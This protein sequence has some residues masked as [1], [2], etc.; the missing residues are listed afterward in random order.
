MDFVKKIH[1]IVE[2]CVEN[3]KDMETELK[4]ISNSL[5]KGDITPKAA[6]TR[7]TELREK[8]SEL[9]AKARSEIRQ[10][11]SDFKA[12]VDK[13]SLIDGS[14]NNADAAIFQSGITLTSKQFE[15][16]V[17]RNKHNPFVVGLARK[18]LNDHKDFTAT[19]PLDYD[20]IVKNY[21]AFAE[22]ASGVVADDLS[23]IRL[24]LFLNG[25]VD[26]EGV[27]LIS[28]DGEGDSGTPI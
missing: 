12:A 2:S 23:S 8:K 11:Q 10:A 4:S 7:R 21:D 19:M 5:K 3:Y 17:E 25:N 26:P 6:N 16:I 24:A 18:Y 20:Q 1:E 9:Y 22:A 27:D 28:G 15:N 13:A 14:M